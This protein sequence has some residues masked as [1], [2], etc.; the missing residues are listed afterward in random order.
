MIDLL[1]EGLESAFLPCSLILLL[2]G[3]ATAFVARTKESAIAL[4]GF[5]IGTLIIGWLRFSDRFS[6][7]GTGSAALA[8]AVGAAFL[9][10]PLMR[11]IS[12]VAIAGG[13]MTGGAAAIL[14]E[15]CVGAEFGTLLGELPTSGALSIF[16]FAAYIV[17]VLAPLIVVGGVFAA[18]P[19]P[20]LIP[21]RPAMMATGLVIFVGLA[22][23]VAL[24]FHD[25]LV[26]QLVEWST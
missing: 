20:L 16:K 19:G 5:A 24:G 4:G 17:G 12:L 6:E 8:L 14:W 2:P 21:A 3:L 15:P 23:A 10:V 13:V 1:I 7:L 9:A 26:S 18:I 25:E 22:L 11:R